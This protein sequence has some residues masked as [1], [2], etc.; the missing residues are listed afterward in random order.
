MNGAESSKLFL[1]PG[2]GVA[3]LADAQD[4]GSCGVTPVEVQV[5]SPAPIVL[6]DTA[7]LESSTRARPSFTTPPIVA[8][9]IQRLM[10]MTGHKH[11]ATHMLYNVI[12][13]KDVELI[14]VT[15]VLGPGCGY[16]LWKNQFSYCFAFSS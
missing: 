14:R 8:T 1:L 15:W 9:P 10:Q 6:S 12:D 5:L 16:K 13:A 11:I 2:A 3:E 7:A 4:L